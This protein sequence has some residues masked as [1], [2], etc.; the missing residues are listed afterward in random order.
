MQHFLYILFVL[1][2]ILTFASCKDRTSNHRSDSNKL[3]VYLEKFDTQ[4]KINEEKGWKH[5]KSDNFEYEL[6]GGWTENTELEEGSYFN[7]LS[8]DTKTSI[9]LSSRYIDSILDGVDDMDSWIRLQYKEIGIHGALQKVV[10][11]ELTDGKAAEAWVKM[12]GVFLRSR[13][14]SQIFSDES[15]RRLWVLI[16][17]SESRDQL[18]SPTVETFISNFKVKSFTW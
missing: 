5:I 4:E 12:N 10:P 3:D 16:V 9:L 18:F 13:S 11:I 8:S 1:T 14:Y 17:I 2:A 15:K 6:P 7:L